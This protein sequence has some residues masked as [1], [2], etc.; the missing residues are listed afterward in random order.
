MLIWY[1]QCI[2]QAKVPT[3]SKPLKLI[4]NDKINQKLNNSFKPNIL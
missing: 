2:N 3:H 1:F 4:I